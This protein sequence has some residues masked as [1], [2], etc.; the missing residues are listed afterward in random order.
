MENKEM[1]VRIIKNCEDEKVINFLVSFLKGY[2]SK[3]Q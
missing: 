2:M 1:L 3:K